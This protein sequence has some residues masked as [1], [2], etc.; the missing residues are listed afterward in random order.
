[1][2]VW[3]WVL[4]LAGSAFAAVDAGAEF[5]PL[6]VT[7]GARG[8]SGPVHL[9][10]D[11]R[12]WSL[13][14][15]AAADGGA[16]V[17]VNTTLAGIDFTGE[18]LVSVQLRFSGASPVYHAA[19]RWSLDGGRVEYPEVYA[20][21]W[22]SQ[23]TQAYGY[24][25]GMSVL[26]RPGSLGCLQHQ[27]HLEC[28]EPR[29]DG[30]VEL[31]LFVTNEQL[32]RDLT[33]DTGWHARFSDIPP[34]YRADV[35]QPWV[36]TGAAFTDDGAVT[37]AVERRFEARTGG[38]MYL[39]VTAVMWLLRQAMPGAPF[40][41]LLGPVVRPAGLPT[42][43]ARN[44]A[45]DLDDPLDAYTACHGPLLWHAAT[46]TFVLAGGE[47]GLRGD[48]AAFPRV[49]GDAACVIPE[50]GGAVGVLS[51]GEALAGRLPLSPL[52]VPRFPG[53]LALSTVTGGNPGQDTF[54][55]SLATA[56][57]DRDGLDGADE[58]RLGTSDFSRDSDGDGVTDGYEVRLANTD[59]RDAGS[60]PPGT[61][62][63]AD[64]GYSPLVQERLPLADVTP[65]LAPSGWVC[66]PGRCFDSRGRQ[67]L[68]APTAALLWPDPGRRF[69][70][71]EEGSRL[72]RVSA[73]GN[74][75]QVGSADEVRS[76]AGLTAGAPLEL[77]VGPAEELF[78]RNGQRLVRVRDGV[79]RIHFAAPPLG[80]D[81][82]TGWP[83]VLL[84]PPYDHRLAVVSADGSLLPL[85]HG[86]EL[87]YNRWQ[88]SGAG[89]VLYYD[90]RLVP[91]RLVAG[92]GGATVLDFGTV[93]DVKLGIATAGWDLTGATFQ[94]LGWAPD[95]REYG[96]GFARDFVVHQTTGLFDGVFELVHLPRRLGPGDVLASG[97]APLG[98]FELL[99]LGPK[100][101]AR[102]LGVA[103]RSPGP[104]RALRLAPDGRWCLVSAAKELYELTAL[105]ADGVPTVQRRLAD[106]RDVV[107]CGFD[108]D[109]ALVYL[110]T[111]PPRWVKPGVVEHRFSQ[112]EDPLALEPEGA[113]RWRVIQKRRPLACFDSRTGEVRVSGLAAIAFGR[114]ASGATY[115]LTGSSGELGR[116]ASG[117]ECDAAPTVEP[118]GTSLQALEALFVDTR[119]EAQSG[120][121]LE[122]PDRRLV[123]QL[124]DFEQLGGLQVKAPQPFPFVFNPSTRAVSALSVNVVFSAGLAQVPGASWCDP[125]NADLP[126]DQQVCLDV[127]PGA[128][129]EVPDGGV[130]GGGG[131]T[132]PP[133]ACGCAGAPDA[134]I[135]LAVWALLRARRRVRS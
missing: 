131:S 132:R 80:Q 39:Q 48:L 30:G 23:F 18:H 4:V 120:Q 12:S 121:V 5:T 55:F 100:G 79:G 83:I 102:S 59:P 127:P 70:V 54:T 1:M 116:V 108:D 65:A 20:G 113:G 67:V 125:W 17:L 81:P 91:R 66:G 29:S 98:S 68:S 51:L 84:T 36:R 101:G 123:L 92:S 3:P 10:A 52:L 9:D 114:G 57:L 40:Q 38:G 77:M 62:A 31:A 76:L 99:K 115:V 133:G 90:S 129:G 69:A 104:T 105:D 73:D 97:L 94:H 109:G 45:V 44:R 26:P 35:A 37:A 95:A 14:Q 46:R 28:I 87:P 50:R 86:L 15:W 2:R 53:Q 96:A 128:A 19:T 112:L 89:Q 85:R 33:P 8:L 34:S 32:E 42:S 74:R 134:A 49:G 78:N 56:D 107:D 111:A 6:T 126:R 122:R 7:A 61:A 47:A 64:Y 24:T 60:R 21:P 93:L 130:D 11:G 27:L 25:L 124:R 41:V 16:G 88:L 117:T 58:A 63:G 43:P 118:L 82:A 103:E 13:G 71:Y 135:A 106:A 110:A 119:F 72:W 22:G 75:T